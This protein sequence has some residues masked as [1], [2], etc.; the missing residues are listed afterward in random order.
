MAKEPKQFLDRDAWDAFRKEYESADDRSC[1]ILCTSYLDNSLEV[2]LLQTLANQDVAKAHLFSEMQP[3]G[4]LGA[5]ITMAHCLNLIDETTLADLRT[6]KRIRNS[7][8]HK[9]DGLSFSSNPILGW[10][11]E[12]LFPQEWCD[13]FHEDIKNVCGDDPRERFVFTCT[14]TS[15]YFESNYLARAKALHDAII[16]IPPVPIAPES[17]DSRLK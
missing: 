17:S 12:L 3:L 9:L 2:L 4:T 8:A 14:L 10:T 1:A 11:K 13:G 6:I 5:K 7:F 15:M 16:S